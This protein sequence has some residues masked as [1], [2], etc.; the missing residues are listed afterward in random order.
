MI[1]THL[2]LL[3]CCGEITQISAHGAEASFSIANFRCGYRTDH[4]VQ[5]YTAT[6]RLEE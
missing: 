1:L 2:A 5:Y 6:V 4:K 3:A